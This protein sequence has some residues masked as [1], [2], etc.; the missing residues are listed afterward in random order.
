MLGMGT[1]LSLNDFQAA[2]RIPKSFLA[3]VALQYMVGAT[4]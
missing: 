2:L 3:G 1:T 4:S